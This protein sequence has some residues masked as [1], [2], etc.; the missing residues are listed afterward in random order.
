MAIRKLEI[1]G[2]KSFEKAVWEP[3]RLNLLVGPNGS[4]KT[5]LLQLLELIS[6]TAKGKLLETINQ[7][8]GMVP[9][10]WNQQANLLGW[11]LTLDPVA[12]IGEFSEIP[13]NVTL[14]LEQV[15]TGSSYRVREE[16]LW[17]T[18]GHA[19]NADG[20]HPVGNRFA[21][22]GHAPGHQHWCGFEF[23][24]LPADK[25]WDRNELLLT[26][27][28]GP[29][30]KPVVSETRHILA[31]WRVYRDVKVGDRSAVRSPAITQHVTGLDLDGS[32]LPAV[33]HTLYTSNRDFK[34]D[35]NDGM[36]A[37]FGEEFEELVFQPAAAQRIQL[38]VQ[39][40]S[41]KEPHAGQSLSD[42]T[43]RFLLLLTIL[44]DPDPPALIAIEEPEIGLH[45]SMFPIIAEYA[46][47]AAERT[48]VVITSH[49][50][51][52]L[53]AFTEH[54]PSVTICHWE[55]GR[56]HLLPLPAARLK[57]WLDKYRL[58]QMFISGELDILA[59]AD[60]AEPDDREKRFADL[61]PESTPPPSPAG[62]PHD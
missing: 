60:A 33:L 3:G 18:P 38:A 7:S 41:S 52:F 6:N 49:S 17:I 54:E 62:T 24:F 45:P 13:L 56:S 26:Q 30:S 55:E 43:L 4:G 53:D 42:G 1:H 51:E 5:N 25:S 46:V 28:A 59:A 34:Q 19:E 10:L 31:S 40:H 21:I 47:A 29:T 16:L 22:M 36:K 48:Q 44:A 32:N 58:G 2:Y 20:Y 14:A 8:G 57:E 11:T 50:A 15:G 37:G 39:W 9:L 27:V 23:G 35:I 12:P 61:P